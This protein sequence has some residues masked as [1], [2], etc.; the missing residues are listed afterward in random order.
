VSQPE[1]KCSIKEVKSVLPRTLEWNRLLAMDLMEDR[2]KESTIV[3]FPYLTA[4]SLGGEIADEQF[5][6]VNNNAL[7]FQYIRQTFRPVN[8]VRF[9]KTMLLVVIC[10][11]SG[12]FKTETP[13]TFPDSVLYVINALGKDGFM[14]RGIQIITFGFDAKRFE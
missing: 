4:T 7:V 13:T 6:G 2:S 9:L 1:R 10:F 5:M 12:Y 11:Q 8:G 14:P 3:F